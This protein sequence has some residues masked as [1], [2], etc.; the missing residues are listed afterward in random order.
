LAPNAFTSLALLAAAA[1]KIPGQK[2]ITFD[3]SFQAPGAPMPIPA[4]HYDFRSPFGV[5]G[6]GGDAV[7][8]TDP[9]RFPAPFLLDLAD[10]VTLD[11]VA[12]F[13]DV[14]IESHN[15]L[16]PVITAKAENTAWYVEGWGSVT[17]LG[18]KPFI[19]DGVALHNVLLEVSDD[20]EIATGTAPFLAM[21]A[22]PGQA[23]TAVTEDEGLIGPDTLAGGG[24]GNSYG[25]RTSPSGFID[26]AQTGLPGGALAVVPSAQS[27]L[28]QYNDLLVAP[29]L[30]ASQVQAAI[31]ALKVIIAGGSPV[32]PGRYDLSVNEARV[33][34]AS[35]GS[36]NMI[37]GTMLNEVGAFTGIGPAPAHTG[38]KAMLGFK[39]HSGVPLGAIASIVWEWEEV[40]PPEP[41]PTLRFPYINIVLELSPLAYKLLVIDPNLAVISPALNLGS[42]TITGPNAFKFTHTPAA[43][44]NFV[45]VINFAVAQAFAPPQPA[46]PVVSPPVPPAVVFGGATSFKYSDILA[47]FPAA[48]LIDVYTGDNGFPGPGAGPGIPPKI[49]TPTPSLVMC[50]GDSSTRR[51]CNIRVTSVLLNGAS[52]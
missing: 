45:Q 19:S 31:D 50:L 29:P 33:E 10:G 7:W 39:G 12:T 22:A 24:P 5:G 17:A 52:A 36:A 38:N 18:T 13:R 37:T 32:H 1:Q 43:D 44:A 28:V 2:I 47:A 8:R 21:V 49:A 25:G 27:S 15:T 34:N 42:L 41:S 35:A 6:G 11:G 51:Q 30:G 14:R 9:S 40:A 20:G 26:S 3:P 16:V 48:K 46:M 23:L 4:L